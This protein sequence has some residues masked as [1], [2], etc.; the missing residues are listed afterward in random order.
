MLNLDITQRLDTRNQLYVL[1]HFL[2]ALIQRTDDMI[3]GLPDRIQWWRSHA[4]D[5]ERN[6]QHFNHLALND[7]EVETGDDSDY[8]TL[9]TEADKRATEYF[10]RA[11]QYEELL[12]SAYHDSALYRA[13]AQELP[14]IERTT[15]D[16]TRTRKANALYRRLLPAMVQEQAMLVE[17]ER[18]A[19]QL[20]QEAER[21][22]QRVAQRR[23]REEDEQPAPPAPEQDDETDDETMGAAGEFEEA[24]EEDEDDGGTE[25]LSTVAPQEWQGTIWPYHHPSVSA[26]VPGDGT[27]AYLRDHPL[28]LVDTSYPGEVPYDGTRETAVKYVGHHGVRN[29]DR[30]PTELFVQRSG[31][32]LQSW[33]ESGEN[34]R[35][36]ITQFLE[37]LP[38]QLRILYNQMVTFLVIITSIW[39]NGLYAPVIYYGDLARIATHL[40]MT[41]AMLRHYKMRDSTH[42][43]SGDPSQRFASSYDPINDNIVTLPYQMMEHGIAQHVQRIPGEDVSGHIGMLRLVFASRGISFLQLLQTMIQICGIIGKNAQSQWYPLFSWDMLCASMYARNWASAPINAIM[44]TIAHDYSLIQ[45]LA[46]DHLGQHPPDQL[47]VGTEFDDQFNS[48]VESVRDQEQLHGWYNSIRGIPLKKLHDDLLK[49]REEYNAE[50]ARQ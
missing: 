36:A 39:E 45:L 46:I 9:M 44:R 14:A 12:E 23:Q 13:A 26:S 34:N 40:D 27:F 8:F 35:L 3:R 16:A 15:N 32:D 29:S 31:G 41:M 17:E 30:T 5:M 42:A 28:P 1:E 49:A 18:N 11:N 4:E 37:N 48:W 2:P 25:V 19:R 50:H 38:R 20:Q 21:A 7:D 6:A 24:E 33:L 22:A 10:Q 47:S 43:R